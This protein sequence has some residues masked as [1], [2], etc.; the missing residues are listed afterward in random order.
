VIET[1][2]A[3]GT[4]ALPHHPVPPIVTEEDQEEEDEK[5]VGVFAL[6]S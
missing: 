1:A 3:T 6:D 4:L 2:S 5:E